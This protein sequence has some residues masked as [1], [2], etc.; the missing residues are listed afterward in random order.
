MAELNSTNITGNLSVTGT[1]VASNMPKF[2]YENG[3]L[4]ITVNTQ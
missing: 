3:V 1:I 2:E 4:K